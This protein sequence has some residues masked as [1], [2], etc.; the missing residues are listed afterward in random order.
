METSQMAYQSKEEEDGEGQYLT[1]YGRKVRCFSEAEM[2]FSHKF[3][4]IISAMKM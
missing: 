3:L 2:P 1:K 4:A